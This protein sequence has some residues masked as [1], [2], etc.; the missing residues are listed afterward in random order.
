[1]FCVLCSVFCVLCSV[2]C[3]LCSV[4]CWISSTFW[5]NSMLCVNVCHLLECKQCL[6][7]DSMGAVFV[8]SSHVC[9]CDQVSLTPCLFV[10][11]N[12][13]TVLLFKIG[14]IQRCFS[15]PEKSF[16]KPES[17]KE[18]QNFL[19]KI[20]DKVIEIAD[21]Y[22]K[23]VWP[24]RGGGVV[25]SCA[26]H[27][28]ISRVWAVAAARFILPINWQLA[29][30]ASPRALFSC[31]SSDQVSIWRCCHTGHIYWAAH[32][33]RVPSSVSR[34]VRARIQ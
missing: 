3:V 16:S 6:P 32:H 29:P 33:H 27:N 23:E 12:S 28:S 14:C 11:T 25:K 18:I 9:S 4:F 5:G 20:L 10:R 31:D 8:T 24:R 34:G 19:L 13:F 22:L 21:C 1:M 2:F 15:C 17:F 26:C 7:L 30:L